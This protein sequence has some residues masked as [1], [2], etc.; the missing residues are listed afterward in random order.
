MK[1]LLL[2]KFEKDGV[3]LPEHLTANTQIAIKSAQLFVGWFN[4]WNNANIII[5]KNDLPTDPN[6]TYIQFREGLYTLNDFKNIFNA[7]SK[8]IIWLDYLADGKIKITL[9]KNYKYTMTDGLPQILG[10]H[11]P[12]HKFF[13][14]KETF[15]I[16]HFNGI[17]S[18]R[19]YCREIDDENNWVDGRKSKLLHYFPLNTTYK[20]G[21]SLIYHH[22][23]PVYIPL[24]SSTDILHF[25]LTDQ[26]DAVVSTPIGFIEFLIK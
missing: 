24:I 16:P 8:N 22:E 15:G 11:L 23:N 10:L 21:E 6:P 3:T 1:R 7:N 14:N 2:T 18:L 19:L 26:N 20:L 4:L 12:K 5:V 13:M 9:A 17:K 25:E